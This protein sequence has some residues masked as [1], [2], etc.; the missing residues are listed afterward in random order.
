MGQTTARPEVPEHTTSALPPP[1]AAMAGGGG[2][3]LSPRSAFYPYQR[4]D[5]MFPAGHAHST[6]L[7]AAGSGVVG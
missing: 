6:P 4:S 5:A 3:H 2:V 1:V 7:V